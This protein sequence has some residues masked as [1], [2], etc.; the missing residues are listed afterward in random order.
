MEKWYLPMTLIP[1]ISLLI[2]S[3]SNLIVALSSEIDSYLESG[4]ENYAIITKK[5]SQLK[6]L[7][8][9]MVLFYIST[10]FLPISGLLIGLSTTLNVDEKVVHFI[11]IAGIVIFLLGI[12]L[13]IRY[14]H[15][16]VKIRQNQFKKFKNTK[17]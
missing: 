6:L 4:S 2:L 5:L 15:R 3:T 16:A 9:T 1:G 10:A 7:N 12:I 17:G 11:S 13:L 14:S 8:T